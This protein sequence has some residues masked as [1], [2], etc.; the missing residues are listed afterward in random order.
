MAATNL[1]TN[2]GSLLNTRRLSSPRWKQLT[3]GTNIT[4]KTGM[5]GKHTMR[6]SQPDCGTAKHNDDAHMT[7]L[8]C[9]TGHHTNTEPVRLHYA[10]LLEQWDGSGLHKI[11]SQSNHTRS[12]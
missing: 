10:S 8:L 2:N 4:K 7:N 1:I 11:I 6:P 9:T 12:I 5:G 3:P